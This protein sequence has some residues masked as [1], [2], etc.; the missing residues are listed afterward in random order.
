MPARDDIGEASIVTPTGVTANARRSPRRWTIVGI[1]LAV[2]AISALVLVIERAAVL[3]W[4][5]SLLVFEDD[6][7]PADV[8]LPLAG[9]DWDREI[10]AAE[11]FRSGHARTVLLTLEPEAAT[12]TYLVDRGVH[13]PTAEE[14]RLQVLVAL[15]VPRERITVI[16]QPVTSTLD[17]ARFVGEW[18]ARSGVRAVIIVSTPYHTARAKYIFERYAATPRTRFIVRPTTRGE[19]RPDNWWTSRAMLREG[20][21]E[22]EK[23]I[24]YRLR[25]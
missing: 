12:R 22:L 5:G 7:V 16:K 13:L 20:I 10:E 11:L 14:I 23:L 1:V 24:A 9:G 4:T 15:G 19:F 8:V 17:E 18:A 3:T 25:Y 2:A 21:F 6:L